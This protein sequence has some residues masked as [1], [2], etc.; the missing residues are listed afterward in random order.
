MT[1]LC[2]S[3]EIQQEKIGLQFFIY[4]PKNVKEHYGNLAGVSFGGLT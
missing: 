2:K 1:T 3:P 4:G